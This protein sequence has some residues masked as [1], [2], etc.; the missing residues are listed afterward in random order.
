VGV[1]HLNQGGEFIVGMPIGDGFT[2][3]LPHGPPLW[4]LHQPDNPKPFAP[5][6]SGHKGNTPAGA[7]GLIAAG[8]AL[9][10]PSE[11]DGKRGFPDGNLYRE[12]P[13]ATSRGTSVFGRLFPCRIVSK[14]ASNSG[15]VVA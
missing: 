3:L 4:T 9:I 8:L 7:G 13:V 2:N 11:G 15:F 6:G 12:T 14:I 10:I 1:V 5:R